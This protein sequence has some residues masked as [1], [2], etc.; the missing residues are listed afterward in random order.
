MENHRRKEFPLLVNS[1]KPL[2]CHSCSI[3]II[4]ANQLTTSHQQPQQT[5]TLLK[6][7]WLETGKHRNFWVWALGTQLSVYSE[8][9]WYTQG[10]NRVIQL[11]LLSPQTFYIIKTWVLEKYVQNLS[12]ESSSTGKSSK[13]N[14]QWEGM[15]LSGTFSLWPTELQMYDVGQVFLIS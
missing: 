11:A 7:M 12:Q 10:V 4:L 1:S 8:L 15:N 3:W 2:H 5:P 13:K 9:P 6:H 14:N